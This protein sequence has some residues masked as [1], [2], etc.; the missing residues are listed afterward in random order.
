[1]HIKNP[2]ILDK[3][4]AAMNLLNDLIEEIKNYQ[5]KSLFFQDPRVIEGWLLLAGE[6]KEIEIEDGDERDEKWEQRSEPF[7]A[8]L[9]ARRDLFLKYK[10]L[11]RKYNDPLYS[12]WMNCG[13]DGECISAD[14]QEALKA[15]HYEKILNVEDFDQYLED[16]NSRSNDARYFV[17]KT[18]GYIYNIFN[19]IVN[20]SGQIVID[21]NP[22]QE[23]FV[24]AIDDDLREWT[25]SF[26]K[27]MFREMK[28][29]LNRHYKEYRTAPYTPELWG[30]LLAT[31]EEALNLAKRKGLA[32]CDTAKQE[33]WGEDMKKQMDENSELM[34]L[35]YSSCRTDEL[36]DLR[37]VDDVQRFISLLTP[38]NLS[39][40]YDIIV[41]RNLIQCEMFPELKTQHEEWLERD[42][43]GLDNSEE[44]N[45]NLN[46]FAPKKQLQEFLKGAWF[47]E[48]RAREKYDAT[49]TDAF[50]E[51]LMASE[52][53]KDIA[54]DW[55][56][57]G[58]R[59]KKN[60]I[61]AYVVGLLKDEGVLKGSYDSIAEIIAVMDNSRTFSNYMSRGKEQ[62]Y[63]GWVK[64]YV[65][66]SKEQ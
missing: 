24:K 21:L 12:L 15:D 51:A 50:V 41:R 31:D 17:Y 11:Y 45:G 54:R 46:L 4:Q 36:F 33:H 63:A 8:S 5:D 48:V 43:G 55:A 32:D 13:L 20:K 42:N 47:T 37:M 6:I 65:S 52:F 26:G 30:E 29:D 61:K 2:S 62:P 49:W 56:V 27:S 9:I 7:A 19:A 22:S 57:K 44:S 34:Q 10:E 3:I 66:E 53:G 39:M 23:D 64:E 28:E 18:L 59:E 38:D 40:F 1:M 16:V 25:F 14:A 35:I 60:Q 58:A